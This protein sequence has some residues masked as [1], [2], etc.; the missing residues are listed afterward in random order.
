MFADDTNIVFFLIQ[1]STP[2]LTKATAYST[3]L[4]WFFSWILL[5]LLAR[6][7]FFRFQLRN[8]QSINFH[9]RSSDEPMQAL[10]D[11]N[12][13][14]GKRRSAYKSFPGF[15]FMFSGLPL[16]VCLNKAAGC[17]W[18]LT[19]K[20]GKYAR[21]T[22]LHKKKQ[23]QHFIWCNVFLARSASVKFHPC[24]LLHWK[25]GRRGGVFWQ[26][27]TL[28]H[29][30]LSTSI[31]VALWVC[32]VSAWQPRWRR[33]PSQRNCYFRTHG[34]QSVTQRGGFRSR[35]YILQHLTIDGMVE[36][37]CCVRLPRMTTFIFYSSITL[38]TARIGRKSTKSG[39]PTASFSSVALYRSKHRDRS[40]WMFWRWSKRGQNEM[41]GSNDM[42]GKMPQLELADR[43]GRG[44]KR[45]FMDMK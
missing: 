42:R 11:E 22:G 16:R 27:P 44:P 43:S 29:R 13:H 25:T 26:S 4:Q 19:K 24:Y 34:P 23:N 45:R 10:R 7:S 1:T 38:L 6:R 21:A 40:C 20:K 33:Q 15:K 2:L 12:G 8:W 31:D 35:P 3:R 5:T 41:R 17:K 37:I 28:S 14:W 30:K 39:F 9:G 36:K 32:V 18:E